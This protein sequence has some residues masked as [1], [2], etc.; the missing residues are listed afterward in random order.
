[1]PV[2]PLDF[3]MKYQQNNTSNI[4]ILQ[5]KCQDEDKDCS[6]TLFV[7][8]FYEGL[9]IGGSLGVAKVIV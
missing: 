6:M 4:F 5:N 2:S 9:I 8:G 7:V 3:S 1:M